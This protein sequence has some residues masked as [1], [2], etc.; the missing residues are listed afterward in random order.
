MINTDP[1]SAY[2][3][4]VQELQGQLEPTAALEAAVGGDFAAVGKL[5]YHLLAS[6]G[7]ADGDTVID[8]GCGSGR[9]ACQLARLPHLRYLGT[10]VVPD[11][12]AHARRVT[13]RPD[14]SWRQ[15]DGTTIP[16]PDASA[17]FVCFFSVFTHLLHEDSFR[18]VREAA[19]VLRP[20]G[21]LVMS[22]LEFKV[23]LHWRE[24][25]ASVEQTRAARHLNQFIERE[26]IAAWA[27]HAGLA[28]SSIRSGDTP[29]IPIPE[30]IAFANGA[31]YTGLGTFG[32]SVAVLR[33]G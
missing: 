6:L 30:E 12:L 24:F 3:D 32:Q 5:E 2:A 21:R 20:G 26:A 17:D 15:T 33:R 11:L 28:L 8:V 22:F 10:D 7:L 13:G 18:Y 29:H 19:R 25:I 31:R 4:H 9:L 23:P 14:F 16:A 1:V 27:E